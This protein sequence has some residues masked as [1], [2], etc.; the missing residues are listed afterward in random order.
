[1]TKIIKVNNNPI[2]N[3]DNE[4]YPSNRRRNRSMRITKGISK[5]PLQDHKN[6]KRNT[7]KMDRLA[8]PNC[9]K[10]KP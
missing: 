3:K 9:H 4:D 10:I 8:R 1:M 7:S 6:R 2:N 5:D